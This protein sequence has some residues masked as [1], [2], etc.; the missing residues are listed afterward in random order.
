MQKRIAKEEKDDREAVAKGK[1]LKK[2]KNQ[3]A[4]EVKAIAKAYIIEFKK[5][6][7]V[8]DLGGC[9]DQTPKPTNNGTDSK[10]K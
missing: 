2:T 4:K 9:E 3:I 10:K 7:Q 6:E 8:K 5:K 1:L